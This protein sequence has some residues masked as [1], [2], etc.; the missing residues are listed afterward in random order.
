M[1][2]IYYIFDSLILF[3]ITPLGFV[4]VGSCLFI[5]EWF[6]AISIANDFKRINL[7]NENKIMRIHF[8]NNF[9]NYPERMELYCSRVGVDEKC[10]F[11]KPR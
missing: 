7:K 5:L 2:L 3:I 8:S 6:L 4:V 10:V 1:A 9:K 11:K